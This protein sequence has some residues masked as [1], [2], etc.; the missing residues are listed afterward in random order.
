M[1]TVQHASNTTAQ[2]NFWRQATKPMHTVASGLA[3]G[4]PYCVCKSN[5]SLR[6]PGTFVHT[7][8]AT[9]LRYLRTGLSL[10][11]PE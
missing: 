6:A 2:P 3:P 9:P 10:V 5:G 1:S 7:R 11:R 8:R 4:V